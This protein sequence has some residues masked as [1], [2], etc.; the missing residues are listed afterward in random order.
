[1]EGWWV[2]VNDFRV[3]VGRMREETRFTYRTQRGNSGYNENI[4]T[5]KEVIGNEL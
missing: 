1:M 2:K 3:S 5:E 4:P